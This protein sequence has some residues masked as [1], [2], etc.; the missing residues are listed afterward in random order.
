MYLYAFM[1][2]TCVDSTS[3]GTVVYLRLGD[4]AVPDGL[5]LPILILVVAAFIL[6]A[7][8]IVLQLLSQN[9]IV[10]GRHYNSSPEGG[11]F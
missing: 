6:T 2:A 10:Q 8:V 1:V 4:V 9:L 7:A 3:I 11:C 5:G